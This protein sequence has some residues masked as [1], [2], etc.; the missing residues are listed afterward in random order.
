MCRASDFDLKS[1][2]KAHHRLIYNE[3]ILVRRST[4]RHT[5][6]DV[7]DEGLKVEASVHGHNTFRII[8][9]TNTA[10]GQNSGP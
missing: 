8:D 3:C 1:L 10:F 4:A 7:V 5:N 6:V 2:G 9:H